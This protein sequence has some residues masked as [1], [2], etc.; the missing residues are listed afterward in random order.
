MTNLSIGPPAEAGVELLAVLTREIHIRLVN[1]SL[2]GCL[3][4]ASRALPV[5]TV[6]G[7]TL[8]IGEHEFKDDVRIARCQMIAGAGSV[9][10]VGAEFL[11]TSAPGPQSLRLAMQQRLNVPDVRAV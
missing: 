2:S 6:A 1:C 7:L 11:W 8:R 4:E 9:Y 5:G 3:F 10:H